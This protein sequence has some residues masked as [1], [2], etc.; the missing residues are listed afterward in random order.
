MIIMETALF[1]LLALVAAIYGILDGYDL[2]VG[3]LHPFV[4]RTPGER[5]QVR[6]TILP[7]WDGNE[8]WLIAGGGMLFF[9]F[10]SAYA[11]GFAGFYLAF[12][13][14]LWLLIPRGLAI[15]MREHVP[16]P[17][18]RTFCD[19][20]FF[21]AS[22]LLGFLYGVA[23]GNVLR[24]VPLG[25][26]GY[27]FV[28]FWTNLSIGPNPGV[29]DWYTVLA[30][31]S[32]TAFL[33]VHGG[34]F[35]AAR[36]VEVVRRRALTAVKYASVPAV[37]LATMF[38][39]LSPVANPAL[40]HN[41]TAHPW[42]YAVPGASALAGLCM[43]VLAWRG[44]ERGT[45]IASTAA[46]AL[47]VA[48]AAI[49]LYPSLLLSTTNP[50]LDLTIYNSGTSHYAMTAGLFWGGIGLALAFGYSAFAHYRFRG[51]VPPS[52]SHSGE[53]NG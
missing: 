6:Q 16:H 24:G 35:L 10:P 5:E 31:L 34:A 18:V 22:T 52:G 50:A 8:V 14:L 45:F 21:A 27:F 53:L 43:I 37:I 7:V 17:M 42:E 40:Q 33:V 9:A 2:G 11:A 3:M 23:L 29:F 51:R 25:P 47:S 13:V 39:V 26:N 41:F 1:S 38:A 46:I 12:F 49:A 20:V 30:G 15:E 44:R 48:S 19:A 28:P 32:T 36:S 4:G